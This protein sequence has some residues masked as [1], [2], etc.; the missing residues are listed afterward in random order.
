MAVQI[1]SPVG[2]LGDP[3][4]VTVYGHF[5]LILVPDIRIRQVFDVV[6]DRQDQL[7]GDKSF[8]HQIQSQRVYHLPEDQTGFIKGVRTLKHLSGDD[9][10][11]IRF[12]GFDIGQGTGFPAP[13][14]VDQQF[15][16]YTEKPVEQFFII[17][18]G[19]RTQGTPGDIPHGIETASFQFP[20]ISPAYPPE[21]SQRTV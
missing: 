11:C 21:V 19:I 18:V 13:G 12:I 17:I 14:M 10:V 6:T 15:R 1:G 20:G 4:S 9:S 5:S 7:V 3:A 2:V 8:V 16:I